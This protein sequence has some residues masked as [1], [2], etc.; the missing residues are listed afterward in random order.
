MKLIVLSLPR[1]MDEH[2]LR[3]LFE[4][5]GPVTACTLVHDEKRGTSKGFGFVEMAREEDAMQAI[6]NLHGTKLKQ[7]R[8]R[9]KPAD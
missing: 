3:K 5:H 6:E 1:N 9:V 8:I 2:E 4:A 7:S